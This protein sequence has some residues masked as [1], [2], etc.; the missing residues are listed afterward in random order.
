MKK[1]FDSLTIKQTFVLL[2][3]TFGVVLLGSYITISKFINIHEADQVTINTAT[4]HRL[5]A[6]VLHLLVEDY[7]NGNKDALKK[8]NK[9]VD[10]GNRIL[11]HLIKG[12]VILDLTSDM[13]IRPA[14]GELLKAMEHALEL[15]L[16]YKAQID[17]VLAEVET[18]GASGQVI[19]DPKV[20]EALQ[21]LRTKEAVLYT[22]NDAV[23]KKSIKRFDDSKVTLTSLIT[24]A[25]LVNIVMLALGYRLIS[26]RLL[27]PLKVIGNTAADIIAG[28][29]ANE[30]HYSRNDEVGKV[31]GAINNLMANLK[32]ATTFIQQI[33]KGELNASYNDL[34]EKTAKDQNTIA[35]SLLVMRDQMLKVAEEEKQRNWTTEGLAKFVEILRSNIDNVEDFTHNIISSV[36]EYLKANQGALF[37]VNDEEQNIQLEMMA[38]YAYHKR[39]YLHKRI[40]PGEGL[41]GQAFLEQ[42]T[43]YMTQVP[44]NYVSIR[45]GL[46]GATP[47]SLL[48]VPL[49]MNDKIHGVIEIASFN[50]FKPYEIEFIEKLGENIASTLANVKINNKTRKLLE[51]SQMLTEQMRAQEEEMRQNMEELEA[52]QEEMRRAQEQAINQTKELAEFSA[53]VN[54]STIIIEFNADG[55]VLNVNEK[56]SELTGYSREEIIGKPHTYYVAKEDIVAGSFDKL[57][58]QLRT[59]EYLEKDV[60]RLKKDGSIFWLRAYYFPIRNENNELKK[61]TCICSDI[62]SE[63]LEIEELRKLKDSANTKH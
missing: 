42:E 16:P 29:L 4:K 28:N 63:K 7:A 33:G 47:G 24:F 53:S 46:G 44:Q 9:F 38:C 57:W 27:Q 23:V 60:R 3:L 40:A 58:H 48:I 8:I 19:Q 18:A 21:Y 50:T 11:P 55:T 17:L 39:K 49:K 43:I 61:I 26:R 37:L 5:H 12:G 35:G 59:E 10:A 31:T 54:R 51:E 62:T 32:N 56:F 30:L 20:Q 15:W 25:A 52:T 45:S 22:A 14:E 13:T 2:F 6:Q 41:I 1:Y 36:V 34:D